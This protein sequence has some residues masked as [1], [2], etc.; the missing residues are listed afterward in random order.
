MN[1]LLEYSD[2]YSM[3]WRS[4]WNYDIDEANDDENENGNANN[5]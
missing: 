3:T 5:K 4:L 2:N 1:S